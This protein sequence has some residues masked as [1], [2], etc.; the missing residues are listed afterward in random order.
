M[1]QMQKKHDEEKEMFW[2]VV[3]ER[4][5]SLQDVLGELTCDLGGLFSKSIKEH[6]K[7]RSRLEVA[8]AHSWWCLSVKSI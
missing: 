5:T 2:N 7:I 6:G 1:K 4:A 8:R 3:M